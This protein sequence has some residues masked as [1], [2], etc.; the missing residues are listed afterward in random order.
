MKMVGF[1][2]KARIECHLHMQIEVI[3]VINPYGNWGF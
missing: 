1:P 2:V 3:S